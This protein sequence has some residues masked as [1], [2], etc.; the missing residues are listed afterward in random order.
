MTPQIRVIIIS[1]T[2]LF[3]LD[4]KFRLIILLSNGKYGLVSTVKKSKAMCE[5]TQNAVAWIIF[6]SK[7]KYPKKRRVDNIIKPDNS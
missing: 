6:L 4:I 3:F 5:T 2:I 1:R 7:K